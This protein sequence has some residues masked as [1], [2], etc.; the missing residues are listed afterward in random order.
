MMEREEGEEE[1]TYVMVPRTEAAKKADKRL[2][3]VKEWHAA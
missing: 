2:E 1:E 3:I